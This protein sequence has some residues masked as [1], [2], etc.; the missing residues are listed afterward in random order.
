MTG[1]FTPHGRNV[2]DTVHKSGVGSALNELISSEQKC[3]SVVGA[4]APSI[5]GYL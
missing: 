2:W 1:P 4:S 3:D 5:P